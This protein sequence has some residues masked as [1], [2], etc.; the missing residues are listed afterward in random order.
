MS[1]TAGDNE[2]RERPADDEGSDEEGERGKGDG[3][4]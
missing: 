2:Q 1:R 3:D 4:G